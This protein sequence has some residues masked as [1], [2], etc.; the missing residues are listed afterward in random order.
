VSEPS[1][2]PSGDITPVEAARKPGKAMS[3]WD[4][5]NELRGVLFRSAVA[6][7]IAGGLVFAYFDEFYAVLSWPLNH[8]LAEFP[9]LKL[10]LMTTTPMEVF[11]VYLQICLVGGLIIASPFILFFLGQFVGPALTEAE[12]RTVLPFVGSGLLLFLSGCTFSFFL[13]VTSALRVSIQLTTAIGWGFNWTPAAYF[14]LMTW[15]VLGVGLSFE[16]PLVIVLLVHFGLMTTA[17]LRKYR[18]H[19]IVVIFIIA[20]VVTPTAD[21]ITQGIFAIPLYVLYEIAIL[22]GRRIEKKRAARLAAG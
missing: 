3:F 7:F 19:A 1:Q 13:L 8:V 18:R 20:A 5:L 6:F 11:N 10:Q 15:L 16:F 2:T 4:H 14:S 12:R 9:G 17:F 22:A 21:P